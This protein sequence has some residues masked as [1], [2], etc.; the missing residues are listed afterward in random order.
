MRFVYFLLG[1]DL[2]LI[3][4]LLLHWFLYRKIPARSLYALWLIPALRLLVPFGWLE[5]PQNNTAGIVLAAPYRM[6]AEAFTNE[7]EVTGTQPAAEGE[8]YGNNV[9]TGGADKDDAAADTAVHAGNALAEEREGVSG[10]LSRPTDRTLR[11]GNEVWP[12]VR[13]VLLAVWGMGST[14]LAGYALAVN[15]RLRRS[16]KGMELLTD[17]GTELPVYCGRT[18]CGSCL[19]GLFHPCILVSRDAA[20]NPKLYPYLLRHEEMHYRQ[21]DPLWTALRIVLCVVYWWNPLVWAAAVCA[22]EDGELACDERV[23]CGLSVQ[24][25]QAY[26]YALLEVFQS[27]GRKQLLYGTVSAGGSCASMK[28]RITAIAERRQGKRGLGIAAFVILISVFITGICLPQNIYAADTQDDRITGGK[29]QGQEMSPVEEEEG[30]G[31][32]T[33]EG[34]AASRSGATIQADTE[35]EGNEGIQ[36][37]TGAQGSAAAE[38]PAETGEQL[39]YL[40]PLPHRDG[41]HESAVEYVTVENLSEEVSSDEE[42]KHSDELAQRALQE[43]YDL[44][45]V[46]ITEC[47]YTATS[48]GTFYFGRTEEDLRRSRNFYSRQFAVEEGVIPSFSIA[49]A[50]H[51]WY[52]DVQQLLLPADAAGMKSGELAVWFLQHSGLCPE[53]YVAQTESSYGT[54]PEL[55]RIVMTDGSF[56]EVHLDMEI[57]AVEAVYGPYPE[58][59]EH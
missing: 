23:L 17:P 27:G 16:I 9:L 47:V 52:S 51:V 33:A 46:Q 5:L 42:R 6:M 4:V 26:G 59:T 30:D 56:Y 12:V 20:E 24:E 58:G 11:G 8:E 48:F 38:S 37:E 22:Q 40:S 54:V 44:T 50:R 39:A 10:D 2:L 3:A 31:Q 32:K 45:G 36:G 28:K 13:C 1:A 29:E 49:S 14:V 41:Y 34:D 21:K 7:K 57:L 43:L 19:F 25:K 53:G 18:V 35:S 15:E 55:V